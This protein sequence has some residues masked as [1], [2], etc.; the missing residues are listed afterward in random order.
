MPRRISATRSLPSRPIR[1]VISPLSIV[2][3][4]V[5]LATLSWGRLPAPPGPDPPQ[6]RRLFLVGK[7]SIRIVE[8]LQESLIL[9]SG[10][11]LLQRPRVDAATG[12]SRPSRYLIGPLRQRMLDGHRYP[13]LRHGNTFLLTNL[14]RAYVRWST[15]GAFPECGSRQAAS[16]S[17]WVSWV[18]CGV[19]RRACSRSRSGSGGSSR[20]LGVGGP[21]PDSQLA[22][23]P[24]HAIS[25]RGLLCPLPTK[26]KKF[27][28][29]FRSRHRLSRRSATSTDG[30]SR[31][32][33]F[34]ASAHD[35]SRPAA[36]GSPAPPSLS[37]PRIGG[38]TVVPTG[39]ERDGVASPGCPAA[40]E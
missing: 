7:V 30:V 38:S 12:C 22:V 18:C 13:H 37:A 25:W 2:K 36:A 15:G 31:A 19:T 5:T 33:P 16:S 35:P 17:G 10:Q 24:H 6:G 28:R 23:I 39:S 40:P 32:P 21:L 34:S 20:M 27:T 3:S 8:A 26:Q 14:M 29:T 9:P 4:C 11:E 1:S